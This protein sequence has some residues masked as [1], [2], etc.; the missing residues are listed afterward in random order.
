M[1]EDTPKIKKHMTRCS[2]EI[3]EVNIKTTVRC[4]THTRNI[5]LRKLVTTSVGKLF[6]NGILTCD[7]WSTKWYNHLRKHLPVS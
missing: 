1:K 4:H 6:S 3:R 7:C 5:Q 2:V